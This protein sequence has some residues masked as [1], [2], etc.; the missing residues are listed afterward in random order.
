VHTIT[1]HLWF[2]ADLLGSDSSIQSRFS[3]SNLTCENSWLI[4][5]GAEKLKVREF[6]MW[7][8][9]EQQSTV[10]YCEV[11][12]DSSNN[13]YIKLSPQNPEFCLQKVKSHAR[14][15]VFYTYKKYCLLNLYP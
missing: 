10:K 7:V 13:M 1:S 5:L 8:L 4:A 14:F 6:P 9:Q 3:S 2:V 11:L 15:G 12:H